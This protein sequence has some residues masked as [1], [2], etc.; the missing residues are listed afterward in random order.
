M[1]GAQRERGNITHSM[2]NITEVRR[3]DKRTQRDYIQKRT[4]SWVTAIFRDQ[5]EED[6]NETNWEVTAR[7][8]KKA[9]VDVVSQKGRKRRFPLGVIGYL[10][11]ATGSSNVIKSEEHQ[12]MLPTR[13]PLTQ[14]DIR[15]NEWRWQRVVMRKEPWRS[16]TETGVGRRWRLEYREY[17]HHFPEAWLRRKRKMGWGWSRR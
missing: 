12:W 11:K 2:W 8:R 10:L 14:E 13:Q 1:S 7:V 9:Q 4:V 3:V 15:V 17:T 16:H 5:V 6:V